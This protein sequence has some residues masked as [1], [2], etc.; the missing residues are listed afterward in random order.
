MAGLWGC[1]KVRKNLDGTDAT[2]VPCRRG[3][4]G[5]TAAVVT[6]IAVGEDGVR[7]VVGLAC[8]DAESYASWKGFLRGL[9]ER[10]S[11]ACSA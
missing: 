5:A 9:R 7:R 2:Y 1:R 8:V 3:G 10:A 6:A 11:P 4:H